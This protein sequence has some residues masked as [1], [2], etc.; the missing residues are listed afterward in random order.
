MSGFELFWLILVIAVWLAGMVLM[1]VALCRAGEPD[2]TL[3]L[4]RMVI[5]NVAWGVLGAAG[6]VM[7]G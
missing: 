7:F 5:V 2:G 3:W 1:A 4:I 6:T